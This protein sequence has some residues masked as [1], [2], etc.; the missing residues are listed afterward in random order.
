MKTKY[1]IK[2]SNYGLFW[3]EEKFGWL[4]YWSH[5]K[6]YDVTLDRYGYKFYSSFDEAKERVDELVDQ[7]EKFKEDRKNRWTKVVYEADTSS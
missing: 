1:R 5:R 7:Y 6:E 2:Q 3:I 4:D